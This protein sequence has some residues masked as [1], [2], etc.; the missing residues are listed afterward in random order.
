MFFRAS[1]ALSGAF[2]RLKRQELSEVTQLFP[3]RK[4]LLPCGLRPRHE[5]APRSEKAVS[6]PH[7][8]FSSALP[9][10]FPFLSRSRFVPSATD[11]PHD[12]SSASQL[13]RPRHSCP[14]F[15]LPR[16]FS[17]A[18][19][20][21]S[22]V[23][24][25]VLSRRDDAKIAPRCHPSPG[26]ACACRLF[27]WH[28]MNP[29]TR[30]KRCLPVVLFPVGSSSRLCLASAFRASLCLL[31]IFFASPA[32]LRP[33]RHALVPQASPYAKGPPA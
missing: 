18:S 2:H 32:K 28:L 27:P 17:P 30:N 13:S 4:S 5:C 9:P 10:L 26:T 31:R 14:L 1:I 12:P 22:C 15:S 33:H 3:R 8:R 16:A 25:G 7:Q 20:L 11:A 6:C 19:L 21:P 23:L 29:H 24:P